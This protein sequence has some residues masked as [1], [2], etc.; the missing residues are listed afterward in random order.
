[1]I[2]ENL[3]SP[4]YTARFRNSFPFYIGATAYFLS[5]SSQLSKKRSEREKYIFILPRKKMGKHDSSSWP[6]IFNYLFCIISIILCI[7]SPSWQQEPLLWSARNLNLP[8]NRST[9]G[10]TSLGS[11]LFFAGGIQIPSGEYTN[12]VDVFETTTGQVSGGNIFFFGIQKKYFIWI[13]I[14]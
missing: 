8:V 3:I 13:S 4:I 7:V 1:M 6:V 12:R 14:I 2:R 5:S 11:R 10:V 9:Y